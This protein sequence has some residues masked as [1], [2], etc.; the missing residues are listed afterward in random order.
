MRLNEGYGLFM[1]Q[2]TGKT[3]PTLIRI[4]ELLSS[5]ECKTALVVAPKSA[6]GSWERDIELL[7]PASQAVLH[8][9]L[10]LINYEKVWRYKD[11]F[12]A[13]DK[14]WGVIV[15]DESHFIKNRTSRR[16]KFL[17]GLALKSKYRYILTGTP[18]SNG[19]L[20]DIWSQLAF[21]FPAPG[22]RGV[23][24][25]L[26]GTYYEFLDR[27]AI[28]NQYWRPSRYL[29]V[30]ELQ[31][32]IAAH[33]YRVNKTDVLDLPDKLPDQH[34]PLE[35]AEPVIYKQMAKD[36]VVKKFDMIADNGLARLA[37]LRQI[38]SGFVV[39]DFGE[40][41][42]LKSTKLQ[43]LDD[44]LEGNSQ[45]LVIFA[46]FAH[47]IDA[48]SN[49]LE[50]RKIRFVTLD[51]R[52]KDKKIWRKFQA[53]GAIQVI[54]VQYQSGATGIDLFSANTTIYYEPTLRSTILEQSRDRTHRT[55]QDHATSYIMYVTK[56]TV[57]EQIYKA[58]GN[59][60]D[61]SEK[62]FTEY[63]NQYTKSFYK[64][65]KPHETAR[66]NQ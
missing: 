16:A 5:G 45:K 13:Y 22:K 48:I 11:K 4:A 46:E 57:E 52:Q 44:F 7:T 43:A 21:L 19:Q 35:L 6:L 8:L 28:L 47:S 34:Q 65:G 18:I 38:A 9:G 20:E 62:L 1:D 17:L 27:Y 51:G 61:F 33:S 59:Y 29:H 15:L 50:K 36:S 23:K 41:H 39:D 12:N 37:K 31:D 10:T 26:L 14:A 60:S 63:I 3:L 55:G 25:A 30:S 64:G 40:M 2:G 49:L 56:G 66:Q 42:E 58:L 54:V 32:I 53:D 24:S